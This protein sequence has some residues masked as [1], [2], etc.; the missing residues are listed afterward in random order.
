MARHVVHQVVQVRAPDC[1]P[2]CL[3]DGVKEYARA[4][5]AHFGQ[6][7]QLPRR[8]APGP[9]PKPRWMPLPQLC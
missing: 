4:L 7:V 5:L 1:V 8:Q 6:W 2:L 3:T 9:T